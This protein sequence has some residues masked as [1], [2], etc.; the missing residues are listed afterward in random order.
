VY[1]PN[2]G[3]REA[4]RWFLP[5]PASPTGQRNLEGK[6]ITQPQQPCSSVHLRARERPKILTK[7]KKTFCA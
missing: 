1:G 5:L 4:E 7:K 3:R 6:K 2:S